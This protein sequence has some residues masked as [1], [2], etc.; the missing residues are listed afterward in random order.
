MARCSRHTDGMS[1]ESIWP[2]LCPAGLTKLA[3]PAWPAWPARPRLPGLSGLPALPCLLGLPGMPSLLCIF[4][5]KALELGFSF[6]AALPAFPR[7][8][9]RGR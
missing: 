1:L 8:G 9:A 3:W 7:P 2:C 4:Q 6:Q 5:E